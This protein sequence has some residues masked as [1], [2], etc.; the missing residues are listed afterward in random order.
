MPE[1]HAESL[2]TKHFV[3]KQDHSML[4]ELKYATWY[5]FKAEILI[6]GYDHYMVE[7]KGFWDARVEVIKQGRVLLQF[8]MGWKGIL[9]KTYFGG[10]EKDYQLKHKGLLNS[11]FILIDSDEQE[12][13]AAKADL[14]WKN[15]SYNYI[16]ET[17]TTFERHEHK[18]LFMLALVHCLNYYMT[19]ISAAA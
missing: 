4:G 17:S 8:S 13:L 2:S 6:N 11:R 5:S 16:F 19:L 12:L 9:L 1:Y 7:P 10:V 18:A 14:K 15:M 3:L